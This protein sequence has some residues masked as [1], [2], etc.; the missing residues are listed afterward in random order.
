MAEGGSLLGRGCLVLA[1][2]LAAPFVLVG[3]I[4][5]GGLALGAFTVSL[6]FLFVLA[7]IAVGVAALALVIS[8]AVRRRRDANPDGVEAS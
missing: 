8:F 6:P 7:V 2:I 4:A 1:A 5:L 3:L